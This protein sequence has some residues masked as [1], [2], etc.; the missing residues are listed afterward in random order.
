MRFVFSQIFKFFNFSNFW[1]FQREPDCQPI[2]AQPSQPAMRSVFCPNFQIF[3][4]FKSLKFSYF[5]N[6]QLF[7]SQ[8]WPPPLIRRSLNSSERRNRPV[9][10]E[11]VPSDPSQ[12]SRRSVNFSER[13]N[14]PVR[15]IPADPPISSDPS[16][17]WGKRGRDFNAKIPRPT[18]PSCVGGGRE[19]F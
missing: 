9:R 17:P 15:P 4:I 16:Q 2:P 12:P 14:R 5:S 1:N 8:P 10:P 3:Q 7:S 6:F 19:G 11:T 18:R 13:R